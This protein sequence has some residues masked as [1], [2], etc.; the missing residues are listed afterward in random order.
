MIF[1]RVVPDEYYL[2]SSDG[3]ALT[4]GWLLLWQQTT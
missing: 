3:Y 1:N 2:F 4:A